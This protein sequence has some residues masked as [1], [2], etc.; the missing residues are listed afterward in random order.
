MTAQDQHLL[1]KAYNA[2]NARNIDEVLLLMHTDVHWPNG[3]EGGYV[4]G[5]E[6]VREYWTRQWKE[7]DPHVEPVSFKEREDGRIEVEVHQVVKDLW[8]KLLSD[9]MVKHIYTIQDG[10]IKNMEIEKG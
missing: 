1:K 6:Q 2:F 3:W 9:G 4:D 10:L 7:I 5:H 8:S